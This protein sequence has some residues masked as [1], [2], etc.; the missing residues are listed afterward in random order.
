MSRGLPRRPAGELDSLR[1]RYDELSARGRHE[2]A[3]A[4]AERI[5]DLA[6]DAAASHAALGQTLV[7]LGRHDEALACLERARELDPRDA[8]TRSNLG[9]CLASLGRRDEAIACYRAALELDPDRLRPGVNLAM[10]LLAT[11][12]ADEAAALAKDLVRRHPSS[13]EPLR[14]AAIV[15]NYRPDATH[16]AVSLA[17]RA[18]GQ[19]A[20]AMARP[21]AA[22]P[23]VPPLA[24]LPA[25]AGEPI[26]VGFF[27]ADFRFHAV[28][29]FLRPVLE[30]LDRAAVR[31]VL[32]HLAPVRDEMTERLAGLAELVDIHAL[33]DAE[34]VARARRD[35]LAVAFDLAGLTQGG[36]PVAFAARLAPRQFAWLGY[37]ATTGIAAIDRRI[38]DATTDPDGAEGFLVERPV[39]VAAPFVRWRADSPPPLPPTADRPFTFGSFNAAAKINRPLAARW[40]ATAVAVPGSRL[41]LKA[42]GFDAASA[43]ERVAGWLREA[44][45]AVERIEI[46]TATRTYDEHLA[47]YREVDVALDTFPYH[48]TTTTVEAMSQGVPT[49]TRVGDRHASR[50][51]LSLLGA[52]G[53]GEL[54]TAGEAEF[55][56]AAVALANDAARRAELRRELPGRLASGPLGDAR[57][58]AAEL[59][60][61]IRAAVATA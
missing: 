11:A 36:R 50:V 51:G 18:F 5:R 33:S 9:S 55:T 22:D 14:A 49:V 4:V 17:H 28:A 13:L 1:I 57:G 41:L 42:E 6:T 8:A 37:A 15:A 21:I 60:A 19:A 43:R 32:Y 56:R 48:G 10:E 31:P 3:R 52:V 54:A 16:A 39:R 46:R 24:T 30:S 12:A 35:R 34:L 7:A 2:D 29:G 61:A 20:M 26:R 25:P 40:A 23:R 44:G 38:V 58:L 47:T 59:E 45:L 53:L 27:S